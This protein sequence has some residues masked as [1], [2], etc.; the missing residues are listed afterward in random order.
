MFRL[1]YQKGRTL[2]DPI[3]PALVNNP[4]NWDQTNLKLNK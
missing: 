3:K 1:E 2:P 4:N